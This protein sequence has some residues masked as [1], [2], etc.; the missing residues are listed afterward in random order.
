MILLVAEPVL[1]GIQMAV[2]Q[3]VVVC[4]SV[5]QCVAVCCSVLLFVVVFCSVLQ[6]CFA[7]YCSVS[8][9]LR[10]AENVLV[11]I[12]MAVL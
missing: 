4:C 3:G 6:H 5:S 9:I 1:I 8:R 7:V 2:L 11:S 10:V 12:Q